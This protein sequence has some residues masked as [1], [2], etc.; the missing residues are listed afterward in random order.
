[1]A[2][3]PRTTEKPRQVAQVPTG[4]TT[5]A[6]AGTSFALELGTVFALLLENCSLATILAILAALFGGATV[7]MMTRSGDKPDPLL[8]DPPPTR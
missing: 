4:R 6:L 2:M 8:H 3:E 5:L 1:M 7:V